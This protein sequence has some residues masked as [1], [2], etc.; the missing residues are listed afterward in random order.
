M[1]VGNYLQRP[2]FGALLVT[3]AFYATGLSQAQERA[4][5]KEP[6]FRVTKVDEKAVQ[7]KNAAQQVAAHPLDPALDFA[8]NGITHIRKNIR[9]YTALLH[10]RER[11]KGVLL[12]RETME[13]KVRHER[14]ENGQ[15]VVP[16]SIYLHYTSPS[17]CKGREAIYVHG[18]NNNKLIGHEGGRFGVITAN[19]NPNGIFA[20]RNQR[21]PI[22]EIGFEVLAKRLI[23]SGN[24]DRK[25]GECEVKF[26]KNAK[27][28]GRGCTAIV[29][30]HPVRRKHFE[31]HIAQ[32]FI[33]NEMHVPIRYA[34][35]T[36]PTKKGG[37]PVLEEE[38][39]YVK[40]QLNVGLTD[41]DF[42]PSNPAY[43]FP[44]RGKGD[45]NAKRK[46]KAKVIRRANKPNEKDNTKKK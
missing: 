43:N 38:Y 32:I 20:M 24:R 9:D 4:P 23:E 2:L 18:K 15:I 7:G 29:V 34:S 17:S 12:P 22:T 28:N 45:A 40:V 11:I 36:W 39:T 46:A 10:K 37:R 25:H 5:F 13:I 41:F 3:I 6:V 44:G 35:Y 14:V 1:I 8:H 33:D 31:F 21:Y 26:Y 30:T 19:L 42:D 27:I 16:F